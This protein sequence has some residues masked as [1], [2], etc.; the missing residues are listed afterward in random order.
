MTRGHNSSRK[1]LCHSGQQSKQGHSDRRSSGQKAPHS[2][3]RRHHRPQH[4]AQRGEEKWFQEYEYLIKS[5]N[6]SRKRY[7]DQ[8]YRV[9]QYR[10]RR[11]ELNFFRAAE[12]LRSFEQQIT[13]KQ[14]THIHAKKYKSYPQDIT[15][16]TNHALT[17]SE[18]VP[19]EFTDSMVRP[20]QLNRPSFRDDQEESV[21]SMEDYQKYSQE[22]T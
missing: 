12:K 10:R 3:R 8:F 20:D 6:E 9:D 22:K 5:H 7:F 4:S 16:S 19:Q 15:Y 18:P 17:A 1:H 2:R 11:L 21:G 14:W 13:A